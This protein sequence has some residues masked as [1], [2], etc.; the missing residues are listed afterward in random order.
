MIIT[1]NMI[2]RFLLYSFSQ[3]H[4]IQLDVIITQISK[5]ELWQARIENGMVKRGRV[6][7]SEFRGAL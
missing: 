1:I 4:K 3:L 6:D 2:Y 7:L 5:Y